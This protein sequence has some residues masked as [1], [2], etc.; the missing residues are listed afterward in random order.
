MRVDS[1]SRCIT[2]SLHR[3]STEGNRPLRILISGAGIAG[4]AAAF[5]LGRAGHDVTVVEKD[6]VPRTGGQAVDVR[7][8]AREVV[9]RMGLEAAIDAIRIDEHG[10]A[11]VDARGRARAR[12]RADEFGGEGIVAEVELF[13]GD[14]S[15]VLWEAAAPFVAERFGDSIAR[16]EQTPEAVRVGFEGGGEATYDLVI[17]ADGTRSRTRTLAFGDGAAH[18]PL[19]AVMAYFSTPIEPPMPHWFAMYSAPGRRMLALRP[20]ASGGSMALLSFAT[21]RRAA[22]LPRGRAAQE[23]LLTEVFRGAGWLAPEILAAMPTA[24]DF[25]VDELAQV[26][27]DTWSAG[28]VV[29]LGDAAWSPSPLT[30]M[31]TSVG[32]VGAYVLAGALEEVADVPAALGLFE[33]RMR[34]YVARSQELPPGGIHGYLPANRLAMASRNASMRSMSR[35]PMKRIFER[36]FAHTDE[37]ALPAHPSAVDA[38]GRRPVD[39]GGGS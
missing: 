21:G 23:A 14:L 28:R 39:A 22:P 38:L 17:G 35:W 19:G 12:M 8:T 37:I 31:G 32:L 16:L 26:R 9:R 5:W 2:L 4:P 6:A 15:R 3:S 20:T 36:V 13:R 33:S 18:H 11:Y 25:A 30:G 7:G 27:L 10:F 29:L 34:P 1:V 24:S